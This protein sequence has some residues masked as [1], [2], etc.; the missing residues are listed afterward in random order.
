MK[1]RSK[2]RVGDLVEVLS[3]DEILQTL[4][5]DG[6]IEGMPFMPEMFAFCRKRFRV[7]KSAH[8]TCDYSAYPFLSRRLNRTVH[9]QTRCDGSAH[10]GCENGCLL[11]W[12]EDWLKLV[13]EESAELASPLADSKTAVDTHSNSRPGCSED[14]VWR[15]VRAPQKVGEVPRYSCQTTEIPHATLPLAWWDIRQYAEDYLSGNVS[16]RRILN[17]LVYWLYFSLSQAGIGVGRPMRWLYNKICPLFGGS[18]FPRKQGMI[19]EGQQT[20][21]VQLK[22]QPGE[23][24]RVKS[25]Q[26]ILKTVDTNGKNRGMYWDAELV[27]YC[28]KTYKVLKSVTKLISERTGEMMEMKNPCIVLEDVVC[29]ARYSSCRYFCPKG[30]YPFWR[31]IWLERVDSSV[32]KTSV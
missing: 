10:D 31:E 27:P 17:G 28:G 4:D 13:N 20:P 1:T 2:L 21:L 12:K 7:H 30:M 14:V 25:H 18:L 22:L 15:K 29:Q 32:P 8:K 6:R 16:L 24:V 5:S 11:Y 23:L 19:P 3:K 9:L 26:E